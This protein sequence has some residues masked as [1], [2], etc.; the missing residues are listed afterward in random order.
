MHTVLRDNYFLESGKPIRQAVIS[1]VRFECHWTP[2]SGGRGSKT[3]RGPGVHIS[4][5]M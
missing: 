2:L 4:E 1:I 3:Q 5:Q